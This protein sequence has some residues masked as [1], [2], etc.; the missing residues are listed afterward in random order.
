MPINDNKLF[1]I[2]AN[3]GPYKTEEF[4]KLS[5]DYFKSCADVCFRDSQSY[6][7]FSQLK[8][9]RTAPD[10]VFDIKTYYKDLPKN[11]DFIIDSDLNSKK[12]AVI[13]LISFNK[14]A[15]KPDIQKN[16]ISG[17]NKIAKF[18]ISKGLKIVF[19]SF[20]QAE[21]DNESVQEIIKMIL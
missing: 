20:C 9:I 21:G 8:N 12:Y 16:Y 17:I 18:L 2:G 11:V 4:L 19:F 6:T 5:T 1:I 14:R 7:L 10:I 15:K 13:S 3:F